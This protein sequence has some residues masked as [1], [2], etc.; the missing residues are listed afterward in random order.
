MYITI[1]GPEATGKSTQAKLLF[2]FLKDKY[3][4][5]EVVLTKEPGSLKSKVCQSIR[6]IL[7]NPENSVGDNTALLL[8]LADRSQHMESVVMPVLESNGFVVSDRSS[9]STVV[10]HAAKMI[11]L[12]DVI[13]PHSFYSMID[14]AQEQPSDIC[15]VS[16]ANI[17]WCNQKLAERDGLD[18]IESFGNEFHKLVHKL[19]QDI[20]FEENKINYIVNIRSRMTAFPKDLV[21]L[22]AT[23]KSTVEDIHD[24]IIQTLGE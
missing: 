20:V 4:D 16:N 13:P 2:N 23:D 3:P 1:E 14:F 11:L 9:L 5:R 15:F 17:D 8:F 24:F 7:L 18:R 19:F 21:Y 10:Y 6:E 22:P 12:G